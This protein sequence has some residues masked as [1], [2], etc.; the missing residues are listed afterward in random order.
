M[1]RETITRAHW[2]PSEQRL[3]AGTTA[4]K[5]RINVRAVHCLQLKKGAAGVAELN[6]VDVTHHEDGLQAAPLF[7]AAEPSRAAR[8]RKGMQ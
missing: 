2:P 8:A 7:V 4:G 3:C 5:V 6:I 1:D